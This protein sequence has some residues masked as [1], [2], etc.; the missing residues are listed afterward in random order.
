VTTLACLIAGAVF[1]AIGDDL[2]VGAVAIGIGGL[3]GAFVALRTLGPNRQK[4]LADARNAGSQ[5]ADRLMGRYQEQLTL[6]DS[7]LQS[8]HVKIAELERRED[9]WK[10]ER[11]ELIRRIGHLEDT[12]KRH[13]INGV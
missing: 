10:E 1:A 8:C 4:I 13:G 5:E 11:L 9:E 2:N 3:A 7:R 6:A 12:L